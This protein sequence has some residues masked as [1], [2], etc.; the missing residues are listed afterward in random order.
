MCNV[1]YI[2]VVS[3]III[4]NKCISIAIICNV[5]ISIGAVSTGAYPNGT[6]TRLHC[7]ALLLALPAN[8]T[9][10]VMINSN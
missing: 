9:L 4:S 1:A 10:G 8:I 3:N 5:I 7:E 6:L 2:N